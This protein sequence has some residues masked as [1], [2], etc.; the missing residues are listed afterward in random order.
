MSKQG[1]K[2]DTLK[3]ILDAAEKLFAQRGFH[4]TST[5]QIATEAGISI[6]TLHYHCENKLN[7]YH[8]VLRR[9]VIP[10]TRMIDDHVQTM[11]SQDIS[12]D[13]VLREFTDRIIDELFNVVGENPNYA[14]LFL[15]QWL[16]QDPELRKVEQEELMPSISEW[17]KQAEATVNGERR[18]GIDLPLVL[19][20]LS[21]IYW[22]LHVS[23]QFIG[24]LLGIDPESPEYRH[25]L[26]EHAKNITE[27]MLG[28]RLPGAQRKRGKSL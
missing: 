8:M 28:S 27:R 13:R 16:E 10:V 14:S 2:T 9:S 3:R 7:L 19:L 4:G 17:V 25:R 18:S 12:D 5:R 23:P 21:W 26:K 6:Q 11:L 1:K 20:S 15:R 24:T 22:G